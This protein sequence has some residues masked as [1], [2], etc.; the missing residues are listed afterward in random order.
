MFH[1]MK[2]MNSP[3]ELA[4][5]ISMGKEAHGRSL[6]KEISA[7]ERELVVFDALT[8]EC[9]SLDEFRRRQHDRSHQRARSYPGGRKKP[10]SSRNSPYSSSFLW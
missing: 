1:R 9:M 3:V 5:L 6:W 8:S 4:N 2:K 10:T 7:G